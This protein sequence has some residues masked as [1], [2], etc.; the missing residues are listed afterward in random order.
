LKVKIKGVS[1]FLADGF[2]VFM[3]HV[4]MLLVENEFGVLTRMAGLFSGRGF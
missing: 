2:E 1:E 3:R 4:I